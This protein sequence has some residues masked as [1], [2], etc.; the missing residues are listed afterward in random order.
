MT[1]LVI[2][3]QAVGFSPGNKSCNFPRNSMNTD[4]L[5]NKVNE[6]GRKILANN[7]SC[8]AC[9]SCAKHIAS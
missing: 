1:L 5:R 4:S 2:L 3:A 8:H 6:A 7:Y 9:V